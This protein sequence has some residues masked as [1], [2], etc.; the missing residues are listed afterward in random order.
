[1]ARNPANEYDLNIRHHQG[2]E[3]DFC[4]IWKS[5]NTDIGVNFTVDVYRTLH[6][7]RGTTQVIRY[8]ATSEPCNVGL[9]PLLCIALRYSSTSCMVCFAALQCSMVIER[10][11][12]LWKR[13]HYEHYGPALG[14][15]SAFV[16][17]QKTSH[18]SREHVANKII[19]SFAVTAWV[20]RNVDFT[21]RLFY[22]S[23]V[24]EKT[25]DRA[26]I[27]TYGLCGID[28]IT[29]IVLSYNLHHVYELRRRE[30]IGEECLVPIFRGTASCRRLCIGC[31]FFY[32]GDE[33]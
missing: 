31:N 6:L 33:M 16:S 29:L 22:C 14:I 3:K 27:L 13:Q 12:A 21:S 15:T 4:T 9:P 20:V 2:D 24:T 25:V 11:V 1:M 8:L 23:T 26:T 5:T 18:T 10:A 30:F 19:V 17:V 32:R 28:L 7:H